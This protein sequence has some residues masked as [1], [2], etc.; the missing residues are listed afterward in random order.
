MEVR[1]LPVRVP[2]VLVALTGLSVF[3]P[4]A[5]ANMP[6]I[7]GRLQIDYASEDRA[8]ETGDV[9]RFDLRRFRLG[10]EGEVTS[11]LSYEFEIDIDDDGVIELEDAYLNFESGDG[12]FIRFGQFNTPNSLDEQTSSRFLAVFERAGFVDAFDLGRQVGVLGGFEREDWRIEAGLF[13]ANLKDGDLS[14]VTSLAARA[15]YSPAFGETGRFHL[16]ASFRTRE[17][18]ASVEPIAF[19]GPAFSRSDDELIETPSAYGDDLFVGLEV[20]TLWNTS[21]IASEAGLLRATESSDS[22]RKSDF[23]GVYA[24]IGH[25]I[26]GRRTY[27]SGKFK[28]PKIDRPL[29]QGGAGGLSLVLR[30]DHLDLADGF[31]SSGA[32]D[33]W[34]AGMEWWPEDNLHVGINIYRAEAGEEEEVGSRSPPFDAAHVGSRQTTGSATGLLARLQF[35]F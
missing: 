28:R 16:G 20:A 13:G 5:F 9:D 11:K 19:S 30:Y 33:T 29:S 3:T 27:R 17:F 34:I 10:L 25:F 32:R 6:E 23:S 18:T 14:Q 8:R 2:I 26:G 15:V 7:S 12:P 21:W 35:D 24:E 4:Q 31:A 1:I 22:S